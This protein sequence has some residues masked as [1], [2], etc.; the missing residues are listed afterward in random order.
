MNRLSQFIVKRYKAI[1]AV[2]LLFALLCLL[3]V[4]QLDIS[5]NMEEMLPKDSEALKA[6]EEFD[7][8]FDSQDNAVVVVQGDGSLCRQFLQELEKKLISEKLSSK[9]LYRVNVNDLNAYA[10]LYLDK[11]VYEKVDKAISAMDP[12]SIAKLLSELSQKSSPD[13]FEYLVNEEGNTYMM[14]VKPIIDKDDFVGS[15]QRFY[16]TL[17]SAID[18]TLAISD[19]KDL[20]AGLTGGALIADIE[21]DSVAF[22]GFT[23]TFLLT[24]LLIILLIVVSYRKIILPISFVY[25]LLLGTL[26]AAAIAWMIY[27]SL[28]MFSVSF[29]LLLIGLGID[30]A[31]HLISRYYEERGTGVSV[32]DATVTAVQE[33]GVGIFYGAVTTAIAFLAFIMARFKAF[34]QMGVISCVGIMVLCLFMILII[35]ALIQLLERKRKSHETRTPEFRFLGTIGNAA[36]KHPLFVILA[37]ILLIPLF[38]SQVSNARIIGD[39]DKIYPSNLESRKWEN[40]LIDAFGYSPNVLTFM[41]TDE[42]ELLECTQYLEGQDGIEKVQSAL[43][44]LPEDQDY[45]LSVIGRL[46]DFLAMAGY[47]EIDALKLEKMTVYDLPE[48]IRTNFAGKEG[49]LLVEVVPSVNVY[50]QEHY[51][52]VKKILEKAGSYQPVGMPAIMNEVV[53]IVQ[54]DV[55]KISLLCL[56][57]IVIFLLLAFRSVKCALICTIPLLFTLYLTLGLLPVIGT[58]IN[59]FS[60]ASFPLIIGIGIDSSIHLLHRLRGENSK[61][62]RDVVTHTGKA[63]LLTTLTTLMGFGSLAFINHPGMANL[64]VTVA[65]GMTISLITTLVFIPAAYV[66]TLSKKEKASLYHLESTAGQ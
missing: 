38:M 50:Q 40:V 16:D 49:R 31:I 6:G 65:L 2:S 61:S 26:A 58:E 24:L 47:P 63:I 55:I 59:I 23:S 51:Q 11:S 21:A 48:T 44:Y 56:A 37:F 46:N 45:K 12:D 8:Y 19:Y 32:S 13:T 29:A 4:S 15:R 14:V 7:Q 10:P 30:Y 22:E 62:I 5:S 52:S 64:G 28:N 17:K 43:D 27:G 41:V 35:P 3:G 20:K 60:V 66:L 54:G 9:I 1:L 42:K 25:P 36:A 33:T 39:I 53:T 57:A 34:E 18:S